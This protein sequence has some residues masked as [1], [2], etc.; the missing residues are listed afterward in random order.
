MFV[1]TN[2]LLIAEV[3]F[4]QL[5]VKRQSGVDEGKVIWLTY[6]LL[7]SVMK[8]FLRKDYDVAG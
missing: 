1:N 8:I 5:Q 2:Y 4:I 7:L 3:F 6:S